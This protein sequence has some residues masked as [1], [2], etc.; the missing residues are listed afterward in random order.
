VTTY[1]QFTPSITQ[2]FS[3]QPTLGGAEYNVTVTW[4]LAGQRW[5]MNIFTLGGNLVLTQ[6]LIGSPASYDINL[7]ENYIAGSTLVFRAAN[8]TFEVSP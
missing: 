4:S 3:F 7:I 5:I 2:V 8:Q 6:A 1:F